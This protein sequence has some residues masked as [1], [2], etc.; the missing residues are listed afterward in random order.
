MTRKRIVKAAA[1]ALGAAVILLVLHVFGVFGVFYLR[2]IE[3]DPYKNGTEVTQI[4]DDR[5][6]FAD[7]RVLKPIGGFSERTRD[8]IRESNSRIDVE[9]DDTNLV[10]IY[11]RDRVFVCGLGMPAIVLPIIP[12]D[13]PKYRRTLLEIGEIEGLPRKRTSKP[14][15]EQ[16]QCGS[17]P[18]L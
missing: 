6:T 10:S 4:A 1:R 17:E 12:I 14:C 7:G 18:K 2:Y 16:E 13:V 15:P 9:I 5:V 8:I 3:N 11:G